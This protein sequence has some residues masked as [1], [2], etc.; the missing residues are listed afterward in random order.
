M[1]VCKCRAEATDVANAVLDGIDGFM[2]G[3]E[4]LRGCYPLECVRT[5]LSIA[6]QAE[7]VFDHAHH[8]E[9][10]MQA[11]M[12]ACSHATPFFSLSGR[13][14]TWSANAYAAVER[15][16]RLPCMSVGCTTMMKYCITLS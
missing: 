15:W 14:S 9:L 1:S 7:L 11:A 12:Q 13:V 10:L 4:T 3:A 6:H 8:F 5:V 2:L 16:C